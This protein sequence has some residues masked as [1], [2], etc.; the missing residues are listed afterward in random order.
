MQY[1]LRVIV[2]STP[3][4]VRHEVLTRVKD[5]ENWMDLGLRGDRFIEVDELEP[6]Q[7]RVGEF[8]LSR[9]P[10]LID[11]RPLP[12]ILDRTNYVK[13]SLTGIR[14]LD[15][16]ERLESALAAFTAL[17]CKS[18]KAMVWGCSLWIISMRSFGSAF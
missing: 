6:L 9:N 13:L 15:Q 8:F 14:I 2:A 11:G 16:P 4:E 17:K 7:R 18:M 5:L 1:R 3:N 10:V 12:P